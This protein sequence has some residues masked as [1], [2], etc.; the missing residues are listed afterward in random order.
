MCSHRHDHQDQDQRRGHSYDDREC[1]YLLSSSLFLPSLFIVPCLLSDVFCLS[2]VV[3]N[4]VCRSSSAV[5]GWI[6]ILRR[7]ISC[8]AEYTQCIQQCVSYTLFFCL[9]SCHC[10]TLHSPIAGRRLLLPFTAVRLSN[11]ETNQR[12][13]RFLVPDIIALPPTDQD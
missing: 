2:S 9:V 5:R 13:G 8:N 4:R 6:V 11:R 10:P 7:P 1:R 12:S 3:R